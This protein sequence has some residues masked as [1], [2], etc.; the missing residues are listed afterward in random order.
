MISNKVK[1][2]ITPMGDKIKYRIYGR[3]YCKK[4]QTELPNSQTR[5]KNFGIWLTFLEAEETLK[6]FLKKIK[7]KILLLIQIF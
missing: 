5:S 7:Y 6:L 3:V 4:L 1:V 2:A